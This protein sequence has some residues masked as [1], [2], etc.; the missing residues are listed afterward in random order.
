MNFKRESLAAGKQRRGEQPD[1]QFGVFLED[2]TSEPQENN[3][4]LCGMWTMKEELT[5]MGHR[6]DP[7]AIVC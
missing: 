6:R 1:L 2:A 5:V 4:Q 7:A 3:T